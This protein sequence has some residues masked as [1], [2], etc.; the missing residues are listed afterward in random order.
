MKGLL[1]TA[2]FLIFLAAPAL[3]GDT[4]TYFESKSIVDSDGTAHINLT[5]ALTMPFGGSSITIPVFYGVEDLRAEPNFGSSGC[6][7]EPRSYGVDIICDVSGM[8]DT[9]HILRISYDTK[10][11]VK[12]LGNQY[13]YKQ[14]VY[15][16]L[17]TSSAYFQVMLPQGSGLV[18]SLR[19]P[20]LPVD[21]S[22]ASDGRMIFIFWSRNSFTAGDGFTAQLTYE[23]FAQ[24]QPLLEIAVPFGIAAVVFAGLF[25]SYFGRKGIGVKAAI[26]NIIPMM[27]SD[28]KIIMQTIL[29]HG[30][31]THQKVLVRESGYSKAKVSKVL[32]SL[33]ERGV[34]K[35]ERVGRS[36]R[37]YLASEFR[38]KAQMT[39]GND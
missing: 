23:T 30:N 21:G 32:K 31:G 14:E 24:Q 26:R 37:V 18:T 19:S 17:N 9:D 6:E 11:L 5:V 20:Y 2:V 36:N 10:E 7:L 33:A 3:A 8:T 27:K 1:L 25:W 15:I 38:S 39:P 4:I 13:N 35:L 12:A 16:P 28:E 34:V 29:K 22:M